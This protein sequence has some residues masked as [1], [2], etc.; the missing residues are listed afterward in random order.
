LELHSGDDD[1]QGKG[2]ELLANIKT[3][4]ERRQTTNMLNADLLNALVDDPEW[5][6]GT[7]NHGKPMTQRQ[8]TA[9][10]KSFDV[11][12]HSVRTDRAANGGRGYSRADF[13]DAFVRYLPER[14][15]TSA[16]GQYEPPHAAEHRIH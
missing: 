10:L 1:T 4:F 5:R 16:Q 8:L 2:V 15:G 6:W 14:T 9:Q 13:E 11:R 7:W 12:N 3:I